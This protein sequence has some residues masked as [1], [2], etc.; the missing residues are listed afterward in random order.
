MRGAG[1]DYRASGQGSQRQITHRHIN[2][3]ES[4]LSRKKRLYRRPTSL[5]LGVSLGHFCQCHD[6]Y[7]PGVSGLAKLDHSLGTNFLHRIP[8]WLEIVAWVKLIR[9]FPEHLANGGCDGHAVVGIDVDLTDSVLD[10]SLNLFDRHA[11]C[12]GILPP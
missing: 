9:V 8:C 11:P 10:A 5:R 7:L 4:F 12:R 1:R 2:G 3:V 6:W